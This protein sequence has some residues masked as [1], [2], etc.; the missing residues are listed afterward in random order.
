[1]NILTH[2]IYLNND[3][4]D[5]FNIIIYP[6][7]LY[8]QYIYI[9]NVYIYWI[10]LYID[11]T[12]IINIHIYWIYFYTFNILTWPM[13]IYIEYIYT[14][15]ILTYSMYPRKIKLYIYLIYRCSLL[16]LQT[17]RRAGICRQKGF[18]GGYTLPFPCKDQTPLL[19]LLLA[20]I[21]N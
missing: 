21:F 12:Y 11:Y 16:R 20:I 13:Y 5:I 4:T 9:I 18:R 10:Y 8:I 2:W 17:E 6:I 1:M 15:N 7:Y 14:L 19:A 3:D